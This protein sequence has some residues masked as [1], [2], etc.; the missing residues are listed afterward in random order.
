ML[1]LENVTVLS[2]ALL[3]E[4]PLPALTLAEECVD[5]IIPITKQNIMPNNKDTSIENL[6]S[7]VTMLEAIRSG[8]KRAVQKGHG[9][10]EMTVILAR[11]TRKLKEAAADVEI[12]SKKHNFLSLASSTVH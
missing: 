12:A 10:P 9:S 7:T 6:L 8:V 2:M 3:T 4:E 5:Y 11:L 1:S